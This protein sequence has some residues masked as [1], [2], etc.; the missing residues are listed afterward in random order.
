MLSIVPPTV[1]RVGRSYEHFFGWIRTP[2]PTGV[3][4]A[5]AERTPHPAV[6]ENEFCIDNL[7][8]RIHL[9]IE[10]IVED[11]PCAMG[12][13]I[14]FFRYPYIYLPGSFPFIHSVLGLASASAHLKG[15]RASIG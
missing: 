14:A 2:P 15:T 8:V 13:R 12:V 10:M 3:G 4:H 6:P 11:R 1:P 5:A 9:I 7:L